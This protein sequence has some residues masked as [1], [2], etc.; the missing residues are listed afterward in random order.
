M[1]PTYLPPRNSGTPSQSTLV[2]S[3]LRERTLPGDLSF[4]LGARAHQRVAVLDQMPGH[5]VQH[6]AHR[7]VAV[8]HGGS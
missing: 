8:G 5:A 1:P 7:H 3:E 2:G 4:E 6:F